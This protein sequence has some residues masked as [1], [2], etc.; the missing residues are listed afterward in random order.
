MVLYDPE[1]NNAIE[2]IRET[3]AK[4]VCIQLPDGMKP[5]ACEIEA[6]ITKKT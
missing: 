5:M 4:V 2:R 1:I 3:N 6:I